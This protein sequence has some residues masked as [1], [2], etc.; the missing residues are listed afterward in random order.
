MSRKNPTVWALA[1]AMLL[2]FAPAAQAHNEHAYNGGYYGGPYLGA[3][4]YA[5]TAYGTPYG[6]RGNTYYGAGRYWGGSVD[7]Q[8]FAAAANGD[9]QGCK[10]LVQRGA[11]VDA[12]DAEGLTPL[13]WAAQYGRVE[14]ARYLISQRANLN[15][16]DKWGFTPLMWASQEGQRAM[17]ELLLSKGANPWVMTRTGVTAH[18]LS[19]YSGSW[20]T[21][22]LLESWLDGRRGGSRPAAA[23]AVVPV[24]VTAAPAAPAPV[25]AAPVVETAKAPADPGLLAKALAFKKLAETGARF[26]DEYQAFVK[27]TASG[28]FSLNTLQAA[29]SPEMETGKQLTMFFA[30]V[31]RTQDLKA[32]RA[33]LDKAK[34]ATGGKADARFVMYINEAEKA[35]AEV[36]F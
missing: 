19:R 1:A 15:P 28:G 36:G 12:R 27:T 2:S 7:A 13:A 9:V 25:V 34:A 5:R 14:A 8:L 31:A 29:T 32:A 20:H 4:A 22:A 33:D 30:N 26:G 10:I 16:A 3:P 11:N 23:K 6:W 24:R 35:L 21:T 18:A 17:V